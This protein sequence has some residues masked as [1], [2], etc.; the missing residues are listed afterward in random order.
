MIINDLHNSDLKKLARI[1]RGVPSQLSIKS[2]TYSS[3]VKKAIKALPSPL[4]Q[5][6]GQATSS[7]CSTHSGLNNA[8]I[9]DIWPCMHQELS[10]E[11]GKFVFP[12]LMA[13]KLTLDQELSIR[14]LEPLGEMFDKAFSAENATPPHRHPFDSG[15]KW[16]YPAD[17]CPACMLARIGSDPAVL[18]ALYA[19]MIGHFPTFKLASRRVKEED[20]SVAALD[21]PKSKRVRFV[22]Y[23]L[24]EC[25]DGDTLYRS[26]IELGIALKKASKEVKAERKAA[27]K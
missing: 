11:L 24:K 20:L 23:W 8:L 22:R 6:S 16:S 27:K 4:R 2:L 18:K 19:G 9:D 17:H 7:L 15:K 10:S 14:A 12:L 3:S 13:R 5:S 21:N 25:S 1:L 26:A